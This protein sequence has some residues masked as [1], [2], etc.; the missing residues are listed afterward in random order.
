M[1]HTETGAF[2]DRSMAHAADAL[3]R[4]QELA[5]SR[6]DDR[7]EERRAHLARHVGDLS[8]LAAARLRS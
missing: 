8:A 4:A 2:R 3:R 7:H 1:K 5:D 6:T